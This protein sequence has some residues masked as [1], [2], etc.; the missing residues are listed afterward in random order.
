MMPITPTTLT[1]HELIGL[2][3]RVVDATNPDLI[4]LEG[5]VVDE[6][7]NTLRIEAEATTKTVPKRGATLEFTLPDDTVVVDGATLVA[8]PARRNEQTGGSTWHSA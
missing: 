4:G 1:R 7:T 8:R 5:R 6:T 3:V 2:T